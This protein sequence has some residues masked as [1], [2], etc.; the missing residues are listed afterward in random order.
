M[1]ARVS[2][3]IVRRR[4]SKAHP[5]LVVIALTAALGGCSLA[6]KYKQPQPPVPAEWPQGPA[7][8]A[9]SPSA[10]M[11]SE[12]GWGEF[13]A[14]D[15]LRHIVELSMANNRDLRM[16]TLNI[17]RARAVY[18]I[19]RADQFPTIEAV[20]SG[21]AQKIPGSISPTRDGST[22][23]E[24][25]V[26]VGFA[27]YELDLFGRVRNLKEQALQQYLA[28]VETRRSA[29]ISL[30][31]E[32]AA[33]WVTLASDQALLQL[34]RNTLESRQRSFELTQRSYE[35]GIASA[36]DLERARTS[37]ETAR[38][39]VA[40]YTRFVA[41]DRNALQLLVG[42]PVPETLLPDASVD[43]VTALTDLPAGVLSSVLLERPDILAAER[44]LIGA[45]ASIGAAR[46]AFFPSISLTAFG[47]TASNSL[48]GLFGGGSGAWTFLPQIAQPIFDAGR[49]RA[50]LRIT[51]TDRDIFLFLADYEKAIQI[52]FREVAD[53]LAGRGTIDDQLVAQRALVGATQRTYELTDARYRAGIDSSLSLLD[54]QRELYAAQRS[55]IVTQ[56]ARETNLVTL[57]KV[58]GGG[59]RRGP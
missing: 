19:Q 44:R 33:V 40:A 50:R 24:Y 28:I 25:R 47:G 56:L 7:Y 15:R 54:A 57:Y 35:L 49:N 53:A 58:L 46:A 55:L 38:D 11:V 23:R 22:Y 21:T 17:E 45:Y 18:H 10:A 43:P 48:S 41:Q 14:D 13:Y 42:A 27:S 52:A 26:E 59:W 20:A 6:P 39:D 9:S 37:V 4:G 51:E 5:W 32:V 2:R 34:A 8:E 1:D 36:L 30:V 12:I 31:A 3:S 16:S 29:Y